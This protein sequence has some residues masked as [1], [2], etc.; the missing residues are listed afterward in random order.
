MLSDILA[1]TELM[2]RYQKIERV[3]LIPKTQRWENDAEHTYQL[4]M[5]AWYLVEKYNFK[6]NKDKVIKLALIHDLVEI[7]AGDTFFYGDEAALSSKQE[8]EEAAAKQLRQDWP[9]FAS[10]PGLIEKYEAIKTPES[11]FVYVLDKIVPVIMIYIDKGRIWQRKNITFTQLYNAK[12]DKVAIS[13]ELKPLADELFTL[14]RQ[15]QKMFPQ[16]RP[17]KAA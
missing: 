8:R 10:L 6:V 16:A 15:N 13:P 7:H 11:C 9:D 2:I 14:L 12:K 5:L 4:T 1:F 3:I 17:T